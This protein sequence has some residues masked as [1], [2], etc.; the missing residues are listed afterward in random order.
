MSSFEKHQEQ[1]YGQIRDCVHRGQKDDLVKF[2]KEADV[3]YTTLYGWEREIKKARNNAQSGM[4][5]GQGAAASNNPLSRLPISVSH[6]ATSGPRIQINPSG[7]LCQ[8]RMSILSNQE[9][10]PLSILEFFEEMIR[11]SAPGGSFSVQVPR[12]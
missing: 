12:S 10:L 1:V 7:I 4:V 11:P 2:S 9:V 5:F 6:L 8:A 3:S